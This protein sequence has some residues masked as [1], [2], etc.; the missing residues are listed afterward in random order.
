MPSASESGFAPRLAFGKPLRG[1][2]LA[3]V[4]GKGGRADAVWNNDDG[5]D[6]L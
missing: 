6:S 4:Y 3:E 1:R 2:E 5:I